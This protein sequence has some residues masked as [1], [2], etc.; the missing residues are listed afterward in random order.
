MSPTMPIEIDRSSPEPLYRQV[1]GSLRRAIDDGRLRPGQRVPSVRAL[2]SQLAVGR[3]TIATAYD[4]LA[5]DGYLVGRIGFGTVVAP[6]PPPV[7]AGD[8]PFGARSAPPQRPLPVRLP[9]LRSLPTGASADGVGPAPARLQ[10]R[11]DLRGS[12]AAGWSGGAGERDGG[13]AVG[14]A[15]ERLLRD[16]FRRVAERGGGE[17]EDPAGDARLRAAV[18]A[19]LRAT[20]AARCE[21]EQIVILS[22]AVIG[23]GVIGRLW[24]GDGRRLAVEDPGDPAVRRA[25]L[26]SGGEAIAV[27]VDGHGLRADL[28]PDRAE[29]LAVAPTVHAPTG[30]TMPLARRL[31]LLSWASTTGALIVEDGRLDGL[32]LRSAPP[33]CLQGLDN[34]GRVVHV[35]SFETLMHGGVR[36]AYAVLP[37]NL[38]EPFVAG[39]EAF[40]PGASPV[41]QRALGRFLAD[42]LLDRHVAR[43]RRVLLDRHYAALQALERELGWLGDTREASGGTRVILRI[44]DPSWTA[45]EVAL[46]AAEVGV[47]IDPL[48]PARVAPAPDRELVVDYGRLEPLEL[49]AALRLLARTLR[50]SRRPVPAVAGDFAGLAVRA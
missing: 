42:G 24:L 15:L 21:P 32:V 22:G 1:A 50:A 25:M 35:G 3:P 9:A 16:E 14:P 33:P 39:L 38:V 2:A 19:H 8:A 44:E 37:P 30:A 27:P 45:S 12:A 4:Q 23:F 6:E 31:R 10:P 7:V 49:R 43:V 34:D 47:A 36:T 29:V 40:D 48:L 18:A 13:L 26:A 5:A 46:A 11:F 28:L 41:Q 20:R 17:I